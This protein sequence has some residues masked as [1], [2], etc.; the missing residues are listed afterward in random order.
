MAFQDFFQGFSG[1]GYPDD[2]KILYFT[3]FSDIG[4]SNWYCLAVL[5]LMMPENWG[6][7]LAINDKGIKKNRGWLPLGKPFFCQG[8]AD[9]WL[10]G[11]NPDLCID[12]KYNRE[13][14]R[15]DD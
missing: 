8:K 5:N 3:A 12:H 2:G 9:P 15:N 13:T 4:F 14:C 1:D 6:K 7:K 10:V 11:G